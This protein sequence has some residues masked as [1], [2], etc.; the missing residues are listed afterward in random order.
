MNNQP[1]EIVMLEWLLPLLNQQLSLLSEDWQRA[2]DSIDAKDSIDAEDAM[3]FAAM[4]EQ[5]HQLSGALLI[6]NVPQ[7]ANLANILSRITAAIHQNLL[8]DIPYQM[9]QFAH[10]S[11]QYDL[12]QYV[13]TGSY[14]EVLIVRII[15]KLAQILMP[16]TTDSEQISNLQTPTSRFDY[17]VRYPTTSNQNIIVTMPV[18]PVTRALTASQYY[19]LLTVWRLQVR[20]LLV[21]NSNL[22]LALLLLEKVSHCLWQVTVKA[23]QHLWY[24][25]E[26]WLNNLARNE[27]PIPAH[28][29]SILAQLEPLIN[30]ESSI[31]DAERIENLIADIYIQ[32]N[33]LDSTDGHAQVFLSHSLKPI[34]T[35]VQFFSRIFSD[36]D[37]VIFALDEPTTMLA[38]L[39]HIKTQ[40][41]LRGWSHYENQV[42]QILAD[43]TDSVE[44]KISFTEVHWKIEQ[45][46]QDLYGAIL[47]TEHLI[48]NQIGAIAPFVPTDSTGMAQ[49]NIEPDIM[50]SIPEDTLRQLRVTM[51]QIKHRFNNYVQRQ[52]IHLL[53]TADTFSDMGEIFDDMGLSAVRQVTDKLGV[54][55]VQLTEYEVSTPSWELTQ[56]IANG[57][58]SLELLLDYLAQQVFDQLLLAQAEASIE[59]ALERLAVLIVHP[60]DS[61]DDSAAMVHLDA[62]YKSDDVLR[63]ND[64]GAVVPENQ[65]STDVDTDVADE[66]INDNIDDINSRDDTIHHSTDA[67]AL[68]KT[69][70]LASQIEEAAVQPE[71]SAA[72]IAVR[73]QLQP[74]NF[75]SD[76]EIREIFIEEASEVIADLDDF[77][78]IWEQDPQDLTPLTEV[79]R[80]FHTLKGSG[81]MV[82]AFSISEMAWSIENLLCR[83]LDNTLPIT[84]DLVSVVS[85]ANQDLPVLVANFAAKRAASIDPAITILQSNNIVAAQPINQGITDFDTDTLLN[86]LNNSDAVDVDDVHVDTVDVSAVQELQNSVDVKDNT[87]GIQSDTEHT[88]TEE[89]TVIQ[90]SDTAILQIADLPL[91]DALAPFIMTSEQLPADAQDA[92]PDIKEI[93]IEE[94]EEVLAE[95]TPLYLKWQQ[96]PKE[97]NLLKDITRGFHT[98]KGSGRM[99]G[100]YYTA[101]L[102]WSVENMIN[103]LLDHSVTVTADIV[104]LIGDVLSSYPDMIATF[105]DSDN[106]NHISG[107]PDVV[108]L[109]IACAHAYSKPLDDTFSYSSLYQQWL[110]LTSA[111]PIVSEETD[112][113][114]RVVVVN[115]TDI[116]DNIDT[117]PIDTQDID[118]MLQTIY[119]VNEI[120]ADTPAGIPV[121]SLKEQAFCEIF[122]DEAQ[123][124]L[125][126]IKN[127]VSDNADQPEVEVSDAIVRAFH[128]LRAASGSSALTAISSISA[129][130]ERSLEQLQQ[131]DTLMNAQHLQALTQSTLLIENYLMAYEQS[132]QQQALPD[133]TD[134]QKNLE[135]LQALLDDSDVTAIIPNSNLN[136]AKLLDLDI[137]TLLDAEEQ[138]CSALSNPNLEAVQ[139]YA[140]KQCE[141]IARLLTQT[142]DLPKFV[143]ILNALNDVYS[144]ISEHP[145]I[146]RHDSTQTLLLAG[147]AQLIGLF[148]ALAGSMSLRVDTQVV[149]DLQALIVQEADLPDEPVDIE[150]DIIEEADVIEEVENNESSDSVEDT[151][152]VPSVQE[153]RVNSVQAGELQLESVNTDIELLEI[154]LEESREL[155]ADIAQAFS[156]W[157]NNIEDMTTLKILQRHLHTIKGGARMAGIQSVGDLTHEAESVYEAFVEARLQPTPQWLSIMQMVQD[158]L[159]LQLDYVARHQESFF[160]HELIAQ[161]QQLVQADTLPNVVTLVLPAL[162]TQMT[163]SSY[164]KVTIDHDIV[165]IDESID[166]DDLVAQSWSNGLPDIDI[167]EVFLEEAD[168]LVVSS[169]QSLQLFLNNIS[170]VVALQTLQRDL[171][172]IK[173]GARMVAANGVAD[174]AHQMETVYE[175][176]ATR[177][178]PATKIISEVLVSCHDWLADAIFILKHHLNPTMPVLLIGALNQFSKNPDS[179]IAVPTESLQNQLAA[180]SAEQTKLESKNQSTDIT[181]MPPMAGNFAEQEQSGNNEMIRI[182]SRLIERMINLSGESAI[183]RARI[184]M[185]MSS[186]TNSIGDM[187]MTIQRLADQLRRMETELESQILSQI[188][189]AELLKNEDFDPLEMD[190]YSSLNQLSKSLTESASDL[191]D[192]NSTLLEKTRDSE[193]LLLQLSRTQTE[194]QDG[195]MNS[196]MVPFSRLTSRFERIVRQTAN[197]LNKS[198][199]LNIINADDEMDRTILERITSPLEHMLRNAVDHGIE[200]PQQRLNAGKSRSGYITLEVL[201]EGSEIVI[202][203]SDDGYGIDV[204]AVRAKAISQGLINAEDTSLSDVDVMQYIFNAGL[205][206]TKKIT[207]ISGRGVGMDVVISEIR[208]LGGVVSVLSSEGQGSSFTIRVPLTVAISDA[209]VVRAADRYY[210]I[211]LVQIERV[212]RI[213]PEA[214]YE[215]YQSGSKTMPIEGAN[216]RVRYL[217]EILTG[218]Q[219]NELIVHTNTSLPVIIVKNRSGQRLALQVDQI[220]GSRIEVVVKP[221]GRQLSHLA[222]ISAATI[223]GDGSVMLILDLITLLRNAPAQKTVRKNVNKQELVDTESTAQVTQKPT[224]LVIDDS[225]TV[226]K[227]TSRFLERQ[228]ITAVVAKDGIDAMDILQELM[229]DLILLDIEMPRMDGFEVATQVKQ[230]QHLQHIPIIMI[231]SRTGEKHR[232]RAFELGVND[233]MGKPF[234]ENELLTKIQGLLGIEVSLTHN[235]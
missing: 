232:E 22:P 45:Q 13:Q 12:N 116:P 235:G 229:P 134:N 86:V 63:Y 146:G 183:N 191:V 128:T 195:L 177:R 59:D 211:P 23:A 158:S 62:Q 163:A 114:A 221:L 186:M 168:E 150:A 9:A 28:Y 106:S 159:S 51:E 216:Y 33:T 144:Y 56:A 154:F 89:I 40:F 145:T 161:L 34:D 24:I 15:A 196:R 109:W 224:V 1:N 57:L 149:A 123:T 103:H 131:Q 115:D 176:L 188:D 207:Q 96:S 67:A 226:R 190:Q 138:L 209:L 91:P 189:D 50:L 185:G 32:L 69:V 92:D 27:S 54:F 78:T 36:I 39:K 199:E 208:Q 43:V 53:P 153:L 105:A 117:H 83:V 8:D 164:E 212:E 135:S 11:L 181:E 213:N 120:M 20:Q 178:R 201:R 156:L 125:Q 113:D 160:A 197:E 88:Q 219:L 157:R 225:V 107:Y 230:S 66:S 182:S 49:S 68:S 192:I 93:F 141:Q 173:G 70:V 233:Y 84:D 204:E 231:T 42:S 228:G 100:A 5:Y 26:I 74:D 172:T 7:L 108:P 202:N 21:E 175:E 198:V 19:Q 223:M 72:L 76:Y 4:A 17:D 179:L 169:N 104:Q 25:T 37:A 165:I 65:S 130:I 119:S 220:A 136:V 194:L 218:S 90:K 102:A 64:N 6:A 87:E 55:F 126:D 14:R 35:T 46:L 184:D 38:P 214:L 132:V 73:T 97:L 171:H 80:S 187:G 60:L 152:V 217:N 142:A 16:I 166:F 155:D 143:F 140:R 124:L 203:L 75:D 2:V 85:Q 215:Y 3:D 48:Q 94:A 77:L 170:D 137:D 111:K 133:D 200:S 148:D 227:V 99:V 129:T 29:A 205:T 112:S 95:I 127:F 210:A 147:H 18:S 234:Q 58:S 52:Q 139:S 118:S 41:Q 79:C 122:V 222:G 180:I 98:L 101:E 151:L 206:T 71:E 30:A 162:Q 174:L 82:G 121:Q 10:Q 47:Y 31:L 44:G 81:R 167:L 110:A 61:L 193:N